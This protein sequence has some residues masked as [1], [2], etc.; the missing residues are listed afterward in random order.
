MSTS[1]KKDKGL[2]KVFVMTG[3]NI[4]GEDDGGKS[5]D[6]YAVVMWGKESEKTKHKN[7]TANPE[8]NE[9]FEFKVAGDENM[10]KAT[11]R[12]Q[13]FDKDLIGKDD[14]LGESVITLSKFMIPYQRT[15]NWFSLLQGKGGEVHIGLYWRP[16][17]LLTIEEARDLTASD[18]GQSDP[19]IKVTCKEA[20]GF[21]DKTPTIKKTLNPVWSKENVF[22]IPPVV[23]HNSKILLTLY[24]E[25]FGKDDTLGFVE[26]TPGN[27]SATGETD[28]WLGVERGKGAVHIKAKW[29]PEI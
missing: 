9:E 29:I 25:D 23:D 4:Q 11:L 21:S 18:N 19:Y 20:D 16:S 5:S 27:V 3:R 2:L 15:E 13:V 12:V 22:H 6:P 1:Y 26:V 28:T 10:E 7:K 17:L 14:Y 24:D 8:W